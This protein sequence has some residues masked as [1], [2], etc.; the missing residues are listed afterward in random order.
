MKKNEDAAIIKHQ[1]GLL[2]YRRRLALQRQGKAYKSRCLWH[3]DRNPSLSVYQKRNEWLWRCFPCEIGGD[4]IAFVQRV[5]N[6]TFPEALNVISKECGIASIPETERKEMPFTYDKQDATAALD[7]VAEFLSSRG[8]PLELAKE[9]GLGYVD[10]PSLG[11]SVAM[12]YTNE[13]V[14]I[15]ALKPQNKGDKFRHLKGGS[16]AS[17]L[18]GV[19]SL[20]NVDFIFNPD[21]YV[22]ESELD[23]LTLQAHDFNA[24]SVSSASTCLVDG[25]L[26]I[27][28]GHLEKL[29]AA[30]RIILM[31]DQDDPG[32]QCAA[33]FE[34]E[35][36]PHQVFR[37][38]WPFGGKGTSE[39][40]DVGEIYAQSPEGFKDR[41]IELRE[42]AVNRPPAWRQKFKNGTEMSDEPLR[43]LVKDF[44]LEESCCMFGGLSGH[45]KTWMG[46][47]LSKAL[48]NGTPLWGFFGLL[49]KIPVLYLI[50][51]IGEKSFKFRM[52]AFGLVRNDDMFLTRT[53]SDGLTIPLND[54]LLLQAVKGR[55]VIL[56]TIIRFSNAHD[57]SSASENRG[58]SD[59][60]FR[61]L[62]AGARAVIGLHHS[63]K[64]F[65]RAEHMSLENVLRG[66]G[67]IGAMLGACY[68]VRMLNREKTFPARRMRESPG[69]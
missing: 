31:L 68:G 26:K 41:I 55:V 8:I 16:T 27:D 66:S 36:P 58:L 2:P 59:S 22:T 63:P 21:V 42:Q 28:V 48:V 52:K 24:V 3:D 45:G 67:D 65:E 14:K 37:A 23:A 7:K 9:R 60:I 34:K 69:L 25:K 49:E 32:Q 19:E 46:L 51:E 4:V 11:G 17:L 18:Y 1:A 30:G 6:L 20:I 5:D 61:L 56:D 64:G 12:P 10:H 53:L 40:K 57:E 29:K 43:F 13:N 38:T 54:P 35:Y 15:R 33:A 62:E 39:P 47:S 50:P 44:L